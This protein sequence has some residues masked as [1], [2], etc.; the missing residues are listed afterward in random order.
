MFDWFG[1]RSETSS[2]GTAKPLAGNSR[3]DV[4]RPERPILNSNEDK[5]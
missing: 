3:D 2:N 4:G 5:L 1:K